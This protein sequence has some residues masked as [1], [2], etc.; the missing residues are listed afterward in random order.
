M[1]NRLKNPKLTRKELPDNISGRAY[2]DGTMYINAN[3]VP[4]QIKTTAIH[5]MTHA[6]FNNNFIPVSKHFKPIKGVPDK[7]VGKINAGEKVNASEIVK[8]KQRLKYLIDPTETHARVMQLRGGYGA[9]PGQF[10]TTQ[11]A[12]I[13]YD[14]GIDGRTPLAVD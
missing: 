5:E 9:K 14:A 11:D 13:I 1:R 10:M 6:K 7:F 8:Y 2:A 3:N 12:K 4:G